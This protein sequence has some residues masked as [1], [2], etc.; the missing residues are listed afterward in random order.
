MASCLMLASELPCIVSELQYLMI[1]ISNWQS[2]L[3]LGQWPMSVAYE[4][5]TYSYS[6]ML[7]VPCRYHLLLVMSLL[8]AWEAVSLVRP[9]LGLAV[10]MTHRCLGLA[11]I[12]RCV[13]RSPCRWHEMTMSS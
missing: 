12:G 9:P 8:T 11:L 1:I 2:H 3:L 10:G 13:L 7:E 5:K 4:R 6:S